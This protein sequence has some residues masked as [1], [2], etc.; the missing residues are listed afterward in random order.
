MQ[1]KMT[2]TTVTRAHKEESQAR[3]ELDGKDREGIHQKLEKC[4][5]PLDH[6]SHPDA[7]INITTGEIGSQNVNVHDAVS[8]GEEILRDFERIWPEEF[9][10][11]IPKKVTTMSTMR[12]ELWT[13]LLTKKA[14]T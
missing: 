1:W 3:I 8:I 11:T 5:D 14:M 12:K 2:R 13:H 9:Y 6:T 4:I 10:S 7:I